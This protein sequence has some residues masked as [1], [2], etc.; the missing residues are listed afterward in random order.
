MQRA[1]HL[2]S[3]GE[4]WV[5]DTRTREE[6]ERIEDS[7]G[8]ASL[9]AKRQT[10]QNNL[11]GVDGDDRAVEICKLRLWLSMVAEIEENSHAVKPLPESEF[12]IDQGI[13]LLDSR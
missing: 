11:Y 2:E 6:L 3:E 4:G 7:Q 12:N 10:I 5:L 8:N 13:S 9:Q 1:K